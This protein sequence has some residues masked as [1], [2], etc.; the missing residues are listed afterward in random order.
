MSSSVGRG[1]AQREADVRG[2]DAGCRLSSPRAHQPVPSAV[3]SRSGRAHC[4]MANSSSGSASAG[5]RCSPLQHD[6]RMLPNIRISMLQ[7]ARTSL[8]LQSTRDGS[9][10]W[11]CVLQ[12]LQ[13]LPQHPRW[14][15]QEASRTWK[16][17]SL[18]MALPRIPGCSKSVTKPTSTFL[19]C[20]AYNHTTLGETPSLIKPAHTPEYQT[21]TPS[22]L[23]MSS[24][25]CACVLMYGPAKDWFLCSFLRGWRYARPCVNP[26]NTRRSERQ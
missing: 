26:R 1:L 3:H 13:V 6:G 21:T 11:P 5:K 8:S 15:R 25:G 9:A 19:L 24:G 12:V 7:V 4:K 18:L 14:S 23:T 20:A 2:A 17:S 10:G 16:V 22:R